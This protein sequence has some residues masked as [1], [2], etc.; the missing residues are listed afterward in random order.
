MH[1]HM[2]SLFV[3]FFVGPPLRFKVNFVLPFYN[4]G[5]HNEIEGV[6]PSRYTYKTYTLYTVLYLPKLTVLPHIQT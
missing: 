6:A 3:D 1:A 2:S 5:L 4:T